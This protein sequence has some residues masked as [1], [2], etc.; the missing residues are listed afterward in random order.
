MNTSARYPAELQAKIYQR[1][2][3]ALM[4]EGVHVWD[5]G[6]YLSY[7]D[8]SEDGDLPL[9]FENGQIEYCVAGQWAAA[10]SY[11]LIKFVSDAEYDRYLVS[12]A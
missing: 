5:A 7:G 4:G 1:M 8:V 11:T 9:R 12:A 2:L 3:V 10:D 6:L